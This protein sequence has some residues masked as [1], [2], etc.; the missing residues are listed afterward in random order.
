MVPGTGNVASV[1]VCNCDLYYNPQW[2]HVAPMHTMMYLSSP[3]VN[4][5]LTRLWT[6]LPPSGLKAL[7]SNFQKDHLLLQIIIP[8]SDEM[9]TNSPGLNHYLSFTLPTQIPC[10]SSLP[11]YSSQGQFTDSSLTRASL[12]QD[13]APTLLPLPVPQ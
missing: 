3:T 2:H 11:P 1:C 6:T 13:I 4:D 8:S 7:L 5:S 10:L 12:H 9:R